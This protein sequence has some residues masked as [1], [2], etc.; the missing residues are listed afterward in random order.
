M[1]FRRG[2][3]PAVTVGSSNPRRVLDGEGLSV[4]HRGSLFSEGPLVPIGRLTILQKQYTPKYIKQL[5]FQLAEDAERAAA[6]N[7]TEYRKSG[8][9]HNVGTSTWAH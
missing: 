6:L 7:D 4:E 8:S 3:T 1:E 9:S 5:R 2:L